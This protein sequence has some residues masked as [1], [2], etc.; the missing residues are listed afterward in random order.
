MISKNCRPYDCVWA[1]P[2]GASKVGRQSISGRLFCDA[3]PGKRFLRF[4]ESEPDCLQIQRGQ[5]LERFAGPGGDGEQF[6]E[7]TTF[8]AEPLLGNEL[9]HDAS[10]PECRTVSAAVC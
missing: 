10:N 1:N 2:T 7:A 9:S 4:S 3:S 6:V 8:H 5:P